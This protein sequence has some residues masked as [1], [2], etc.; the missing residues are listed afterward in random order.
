MLRRSVQIPLNRLNPP[1][2]ADIEHWF[3]QKWL[4]YTPPFY[5]SVDLRN[6]GFKLAPVDKN[7]F[8]G[9]FN[10]LAEN[11]LPCTVQAVQTAI[12]RFCPEA[13]KLLLVPER[14]SRNVY[15]AGRSSRE[16]RPLMMA[17][18]FSVEDAG[19]FSEAASGLRQRTSTSPD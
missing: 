8:P 18:D 11:A 9:G 14:H 7:L 3:R 15:G 2:L 1:S 16:E 10:N 19:W 13:R 6:A 4:E 12:E 17:P 5:G